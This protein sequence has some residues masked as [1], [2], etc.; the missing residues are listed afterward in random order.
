MSTTNKLT[1]IN[2]KRGIEKEIVSNEDKP[3]LILAEQENINLPYL[4]RTGDCNS[5]ICKLISGSIIHTTQTT[6]QDQDIKEGYFL[7][8]TGFATSDCVIKTH[9]EKEFARY[10][11]GI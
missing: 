11:K 4:C 10:R 8:C 1:F 3:I 5:C 9:Q 2:E 7:A 6:L